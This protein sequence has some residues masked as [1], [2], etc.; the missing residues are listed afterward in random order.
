MKNCNRFLRAIN[1]T[2]QRS[3]LSANGRAYEHKVD[4][5]LDRLAAKMDPEAWYA[6]VLF[7]LASDIYDAMYCLNVILPDLLDVVV[8]IFKLI[9]KGISG[10]IR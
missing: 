7:D 5:G 1:Q 8:L 10:V 2:W 3:T 4:S 9:Y 6:R